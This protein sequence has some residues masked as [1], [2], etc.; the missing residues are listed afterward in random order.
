[1]SCPVPQTSIG[2]LISLSVET[3]NHYSPRQQQ[4][5]GSPPPLLFPVQ[6]EEQTMIWR[7]IATLFAKCDQNEEEL[8]KHQES[9]ERLTRG[10]DDLYQELQDTKIDVA[11]IQCEKNE[12]NLLSTH[13]RKLRKYVNKKCD[14]VRETVSYGSYNADNEIFAYINKIRA[15]FQAKTDKMENEIAGL[16]SKLEETTVMYDL[17]YEM[18]VERENSLMAKL[19]EAVQ[20]TASLNQRVKDLEY[21]LM[22][23]IQE[24]RNISEQ[25]QYQTAGDLREEFTRAICHELEFESS[26]SAKRVQCV[27]DELV[28]LITRSNEYHT[29][30]HFG[31]VEDIKQIRENCHTLKQSI[32]MV[33]AE[34]SDTKDTMGFLTDEVAQTSNDV[35]DIK[36]DV[37]ELEDDVY[38][39]MDR[40]YY[41][42]KD[43]VKHRFHRHNKQKHAAA[44]AAT[45]TADAAPDAAADAT[46]TDPL[47]MIVTE[48]AEESH[49]ASA[50]VLPVKSEYNEHVIII[51]ATTIISDDEDEFQHM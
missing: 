33:D 14:K 13:V 8:Q 30:R 23:Q 41:D 47:Q 25:Q 26:A 9:Y 22:A 19:E 40:D 51:D 4:S 11:Q 3:P 46:A 16:H 28:E 1:M 21:S 20:M 39:E 18:F 15:E 2:K 17:D 42:L 37:A 35:F 5:A 38:R 43:Y 36:E 44:T 12:N 45:A 34:L 31:L 27:N 6:D 24:S 32:G 10:T 49:S 29:V 48:Y 50:E 7:N